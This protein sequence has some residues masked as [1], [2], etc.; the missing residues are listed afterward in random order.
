VEKWA[1]TDYAHALAKGDMLSGAE[2]DGLVA[3]LA[4]YTGLSKRYVE[5]HNL[6]VEINRFTKELLRDDRRIVGRLD[7]RITGSDADAGAETPEFDPSMSAI[8][9]PYTALFNDYVRTAL[10]YKSDAEYY[11]LGGGIGKWEWG[12]KDRGGFPETADALR[13]AFAKN[14]YMKLFV[15]YGHFDFA[16]PYFA[17]KYTLDHLGL[18]P[19]LRQNVTLAEYDAGHMMY[20]HRPSLEKLKADVAA[21]MRS[22]LAS[23][24]SP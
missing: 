8:R 14:P 11:I 16:T 7:G 9:P 21:F 1:V 5:N 24:G 23:D 15:A 4:R 12:M 13:S 10:G 19:A 17:A 18:E 6:R 22:A 3:R 20:I 2:R